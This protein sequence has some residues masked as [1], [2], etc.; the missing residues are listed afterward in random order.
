MSTTDADFEHAVEVIRGAS[1]LALACHVN[2]DGDALGS[3]LA[4]HHLCRANGLESVASWSE[5]FA[6]PPQYTFLPGLDLPVRPSEFPV[7]P[8]VMITFD[9]GALDRLGDLEAPARAARELIVLDHHASNLRFG[10]INVVEPEAAA[11]AVVVRELAERLGWGLTR[12]AALCLY[13]GLVTDTGR[14]QYANTTPAVFE[15]ARELASFDLPIEDITRQLFEMHRFPYMKML[16]ACLSR[17]E[18]DPELHFVATWITN[19]DLDG[20][21]VDLD[22][23][24]GLIDLVRRTAEADVACVCKETDE[25][26][27]VSL[28][29]VN[30]GIDVGEIATRLGG[31]GHRYAAGFVAAYPVTDVLA[32]IKRELRA[33]ISS[34]HRQAS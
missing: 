34:R 25:G 33:Q 28:R 27:R 11:T 26:V 14:F 21:R 6:V 32:T 9:C 19:F 4:L 24:E 16:G 3:M 8:D 30:P 18:L 5:P 2:P 20:F 1:S 17:A 15:F 31:G 13:T 29:S 7:E 23:C 22:E 12:D 10:S